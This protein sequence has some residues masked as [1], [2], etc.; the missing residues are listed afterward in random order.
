MHGLRGGCGI[1]TAKAERAG[2]TQVAQVLKTTVSIIEFDE[3]QGPHP[4]KPHASWPS[5]RSLNGIPGVD[6][7]GKVIRAPN[8]DQI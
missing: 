1:E 5:G 4:G 8:L 6:P 3:M 7:S 2:D